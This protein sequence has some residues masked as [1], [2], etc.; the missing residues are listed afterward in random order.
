MEIFW[1]WFF[2]CLWL[3]A[4]AFLVLVVGAF[5]VFLSPHVTESNGF[6]GNT[7]QAKTAPLSQT[8]PAS[9]TQVRFARGSRGMGGRML[10]YRFSAPMA[11]LHAHAQAEWAAHWDKPSFKQT[12]HAA[13]PFTPDYMSSYESSY[14]IDADWMIPTAGA[15]GTI[16]GPAGNQRSHRPTIFVDETNEVLYFEMSD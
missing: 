12:P 1:R 9:A 11:D 4:V 10:L 13:S 2:R 5:A 14:W 15:K 6:I 8:L 7:A 3:A 16:Y